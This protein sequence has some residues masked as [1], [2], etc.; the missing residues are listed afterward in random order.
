MQQ[1]LG[2]TSADALTPGLFRIYGTGSTNLNDD[3]NNKDEPNDR[4]ASSPTAPG[5]SLPGLSNCSLLSSIARR[6]LKS[7][8]GHDMLLSKKF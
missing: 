4:G 1:N 7:E 2:G 5:R 8:Q 3:V 6:H